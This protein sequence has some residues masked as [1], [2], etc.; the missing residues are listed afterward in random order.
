MKK[1]YKKR[2][3]WYTARSF[4]RKDRDINFGFRSPLLTDNLHR[5]HES[6]RICRYSWLIAAYHAI[7]SYSRS[8]YNLRIHKCCLQTE[9]S[10]SDLHIIFYIKISIIKNSNQ[11]DHYFYAF[12]T[13]F[14]L[15]RN[16]VDKIQ[17]PWEFPWDNIH[18]FTS[19]ILLEAFQE[20]T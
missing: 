10:E 18:N 3:H 11:Y 13:L 9:K 5:I 2:A 20:I 8:L 4:L 15:S 1:F 16:N 19:D 7:H 6:S 17:F 12:A 14:F